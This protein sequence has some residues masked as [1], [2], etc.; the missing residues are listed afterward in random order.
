MY[1][2]F[3]LQLFQ[4]NRDTHS[5][6][7]QFYYILGYNFQKSFDYLNPVEAN[8]SIP[9]FLHIYQFHHI[10]SSQ[11]QD[12]FFDLFEYYP[13]GFLFGCQETLVIH[14]IDISF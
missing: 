3:H 9:V 12:P 11:T 7:K 6:L 10:R 4:V 1:V 5:L 14:Y 13:M 8:H 2:F